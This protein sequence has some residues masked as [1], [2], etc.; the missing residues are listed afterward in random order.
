MPRGSPATCSVKLA[1][2]SSSGSTVRVIVSGIVPVVLVKRTSRP[3]SSAM[4]RK[5]LTRS[6]PRKRACWS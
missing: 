4:T 2:E 6:R 5:L 3:G 1:R